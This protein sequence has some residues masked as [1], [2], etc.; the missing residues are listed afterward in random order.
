[1]SS[2]LEVASASVQ[3]S[4][5]QVHLEWVHIPRTAPMREA[6]RACAAQANKPRAPSVRPGLLQ[7][8]L[9]V[10]ERIGVQL[11]TRLTVWQ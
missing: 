1:M 11:S 7:T 5:R 4:M 9:H 2:D 8:L 3:P 10:S 6:A